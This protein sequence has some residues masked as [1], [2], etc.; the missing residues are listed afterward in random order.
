MVKGANEQYSN[1]SIRKKLRVPVRVFFLSLAC[2]VAFRIFFLRRAKL[3]TASNL[4][5]WLPSQKDCSVYQA[6]TGRRVYSIITSFSSRFYFPTR[7]CIWICAWQR[8]QI[9]MSLWIKQDRNH[10]EC[11]E[12]RDI[13]LKLFLI[14]NGSRKLYKTN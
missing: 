2:T 3:E 5:R 13:F 8:M 14:H 10:Q 7:K 11:I 1:R 4:Q 6:T 9:N 12:K